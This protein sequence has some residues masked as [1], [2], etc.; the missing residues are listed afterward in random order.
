M[1]FLNFVQKF[2]INIILK[3]IKIYQ[4]IPKRKS[5]KFIPTC[6]E[7]AAIK[8]KENGIRS[9]FVII[10]RILRCNPFS[11]PGIDI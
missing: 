11:K 7:F 5:C 8:L 9:V 1:R 10:K 6:S 3:L 2:I 4:A